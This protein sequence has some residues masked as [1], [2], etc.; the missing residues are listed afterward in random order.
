VHVGDDAGPK[1]SAWGDWGAE[2]EADYDLA[3]ADTDPDSEEGG[4]ADDG[5]AEADVSGIEAPDLLPVVAA[6][7]APGEADYDLAAAGAGSVEGEADYDLAEA[8]VSG[9]DAPGPLPVVAANEDP[10]E[11]SY[12]LA[13]ADN[14]DGGEADDGLAAADVSGIDAPDPLPVVS[15]KEDPREADHDPAATDSEDGDDGDY[16]M[17]SPVSAAGTD[18]STVDMYVRL[19]GTPLGDLDPE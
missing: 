19:F 1:K 15:A 10:R 12:D 9:I 3:A 18:V 4:A 14:D 8:D 7:E 16:D 2:H 11:A 17:A 5:L 13:A 6:T